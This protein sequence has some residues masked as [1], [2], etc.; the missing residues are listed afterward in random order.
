MGAFVFHEPVHRVQYGVVFHLGG[1][2]ATAVR[3]RIAACPIDT[4]DS[5]VVAFGAA[6]G[7]DHLGRTSA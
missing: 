7:E 2:D 6:R 5:Q 3:L 1:D 4:F